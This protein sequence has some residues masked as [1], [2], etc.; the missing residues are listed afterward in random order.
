[1]NSLPHSEEGELIKQYTQRE[2][3]NGQAHQRF[4]LPS[5]CPVYRE[6]S[7]IIEFYGH[8]YHRQ[9]LGLQY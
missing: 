2:H 1:M 8:D 4:L 6:T 3:D 9:D 5:V 7:V